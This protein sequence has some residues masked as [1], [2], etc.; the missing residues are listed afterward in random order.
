MTVDKADLTEKQLL[1]VIHEVREALAPIVARYEMKY[2]VSAAVRK[3]SDP[4]IGTHFVL[5]SE[6]DDPMWS[7]IALTRSAQALK[8]AADAQL[9][10]M[11]NPQQEQA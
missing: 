1:A 5:T 11:K 9:A 6:A 3:H 7:V 2:V 10:K 4:S 8:P